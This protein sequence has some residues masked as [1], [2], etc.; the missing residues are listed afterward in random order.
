LALVRWSTT[1]GGWR[2]EVHRGCHFWK[3]K[4]SDV[5]ER[6]WKYLVAAPVWMPPPGTP[7]RSL[8]TQR[9]VRGRLDLLPKN[10]E[11]GPG[12]QSA[13][14]LVSALHT[15][16]VRRRGQVEDGDDGIRTHGSA[17]YMSI[18]TSHSHGCHRLHNHLAVRLASFL[19]HH[20][21]FVRLGEQPVS[22]RFGFEYQG[23]RFSFERDHKGYY[24]HLDPP[25]PVTVTR[26]NILGKAKKPI[27][28]YVRKRDPSVPEE[29]CPET[30]DG[31]A[32]D[33]RTP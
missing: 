4:E 7:P 14:G 13:Y 5:G 2:T 21:R 11:I 17:D 9:P 32:A 10:G 33:P 18:L 15:R 8:V 28:G 19:L 24:F 16:E 29:N 12:Y 27:P 22:W 30:P 26:G 6:S 20:R 3:H 25:V 31:P 1:I 23:K